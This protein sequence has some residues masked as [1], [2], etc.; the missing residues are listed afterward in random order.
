VVRF[1]VGIVIL[2]HGLVHLW[3]FALSRGF[4]Q[5]KPEM[6]WSG[7]SWLFTNLIG[8]GGTRALAS[9]L[10]L[11]ATAGLSAGGIGFLTHQEW[12]RPLLI[13][14][15]G[16]SALVFILFWDGNTQL[17]IQKGLIGIAIDAAI[18]VGLYIFP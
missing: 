8:D 7:K 3:Y 1:T 5:F 6:G 15:A 13:I 14:S 9:V 10:F 18:I 16:L 17:L 12:H 2:L 4:V 11:L